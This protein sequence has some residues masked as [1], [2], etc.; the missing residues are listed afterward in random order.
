MEIARVL[1]KKVYVG[2]GKLKILD[3]L[4]LPKED[5]AWLTENEMESHVHVVP[6]W[7]IA[8]FKRMSYLWKHYSVSFFFFLRPSQVILI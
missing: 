6:M 4:G 5:M 3:C 7:M 1:K 2:T 8:S